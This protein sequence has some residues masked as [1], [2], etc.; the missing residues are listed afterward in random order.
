MDNIMK[1]NNMP[2]RH[3][4]RCSQ[5]NFLRIIEWNVEGINFGLYDNKSKNDQFQNAVLDHKNIETYSAYRCF[6]T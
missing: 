3:Y 2:S 5:A 4:K 1:N 6:M